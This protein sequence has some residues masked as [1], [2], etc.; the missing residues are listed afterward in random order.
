MTLYKLDY[1]DF[2]DRKYEE[3]N[4]LQGI[5]GK[6]I[7]TSRQSIHVYND[8]DID[9]KTGKEYIGLGSHN[10][11]EIEILTTIYGIKPELVDVYLHNVI[12]ISYWNCPSDKIIK[13]FF[14]K[15]VTM[16]EYKFLQDLECYYQH[17]FKKYKM[18]ISFL[19]FGEYTEDCLDGCINTMEPVLSFARDRLDPTLV[20][21][22][23]E[24]ILSL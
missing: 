8:Y 5:G 11:K 22:Q 21:R 6:G 9:D 24:K 18:E 20:R 19:D 13:F 3:L 14:P 10:S 16:D 4:H 1:D 7:I 15:K 17:L 12:S 2:Y 23:K